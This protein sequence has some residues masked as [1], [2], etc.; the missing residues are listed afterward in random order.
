MDT[1]KFRMVAEMDALRAELETERSL[2]EA[3]RE[4]ATRFEK[5]LQTKLS[6]IWGG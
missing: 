4:L 2:V 6:E 5:K 1:R 3:N